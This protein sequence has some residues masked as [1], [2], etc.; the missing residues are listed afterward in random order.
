MKCGRIQC[1]VGASYVEQLAFPEAS[2]SHRAVGAVK[3]LWRLPSPF[4]H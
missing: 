4:P 2:Q 3:D 1:G